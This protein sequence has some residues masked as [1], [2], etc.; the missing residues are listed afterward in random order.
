MQA[1]NETFDTV[2]A[3]S[4]AVGGAVVVIRVSGRDARAV[5]DAVLNV[6][7]KTPNL[8]R[9][10]KIVKNGETVDDCM[11]V[12]FCAPKSYTGEDMLELHCHGGFETV[13]AVLETLSEA[14][15][16]PAQAGE[17]TKRAFLNGKLD[18]SQAEAVMDVINAQAE[19]SL[20]SALEQLSGSVSR[21]IRAAEELLLDTRAQSKRRSTIP[22]KRK[23]APMPPC[24]PRCTQQRPNSLP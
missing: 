6:R 3:P 11:A 22:T 19:S 7:L 14:G 5:A 16:V 12:L 15:A 17:F 23:K 20:R 10:A 13:R 1:M 24:P 18:L 8:L 9:H 2:F 21:R 4:S